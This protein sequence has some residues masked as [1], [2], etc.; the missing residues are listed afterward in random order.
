MGVVLGSMPPSTS[1]RMSGPTILRIGNDLPGRFV[2]ECLAAKARVDR[3]HQH[4]VTQGRDLFYR[5]H[6]GLGVQRDPGGAA[7]I[8]DAV[9]NL[10][11]LVRC[12]DVER[13]IVGPGLG[14]RLHVPGR[15]AD[16]QVGVEEQ[17]AVLA[18]LGD[19][20]G[21]DGDIGHEMAVHDVQMDHPDAGGS[22]DGDLV[23]QPGEVR[24][25][26]G[27]DDLNRPGAGQSPLSWNL[28]PRAKCDG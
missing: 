12:L 23:R 4:H 27:W 28:P 25:E 22:H 3:H 14:E 6:G 10:A 15:L 2:H 24:A 19:D 8:V 5:L 16:H 1:I 18:E 17:I 26:D 21:A 13:D 11:G 20:R 9:D 7:Q